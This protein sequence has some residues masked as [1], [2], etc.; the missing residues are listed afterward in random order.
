MLIKPFGFAGASG[1]TG[2][3]YGDPPYKTGLI[4]YYDFGSATEGSYTGGDGTLSN[5]DTLTDLSG[6]GYDSTLDNNSG[7]QNF[8]YDSTIGRGVINT[9]NKNGGHFTLDDYSGD[10]LGLTGFSFEWVFQANS[11]ADDNVIIR[12]SGGSTASRLESNLQQY[13]GSPVPDRISYDFTTEQG[14]GIGVG[15]I[16][17]EVAD[18]WHHLVY[19]A[20]LGQNTVMYFDG[21]A[22]GTGTTAW[23]SGEDAD[24]DHA[25]NAWFGTTNLANGCFNGDMAVFRIYNNGMTAGNV[26][27]NFAYYSN[28]YGGF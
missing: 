3:G 13:A 21:S 25:A 15:L 16:N 20:Q 8:F 18:G 7:A 26:A 10:Q 17:Q 28:I 9:A 5:G 4:T 2:V 14:T 27:S 24:F 12:F 11:M 6:E 19:T 1:E 23:P 22:I